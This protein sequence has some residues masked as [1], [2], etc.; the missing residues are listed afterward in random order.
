GRTV[1]LKT[2]RVDVS[3]I[4]GEEMLKRFQAEARNAG[5]LN[6]PNIVTI[7]DAQEIEGT[8]Y[9]AMEYIQGQTLQEMLKQGKLSVGTTIDVVRQVCRGLDYAHARGIV[10]RDIKPANIMIEADGTVKIMDFGIA[11]GQ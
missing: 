11:K 9:I 10:H 6:H 8:F 3:G 7:Y 2:L 4:D 1:A 5:V